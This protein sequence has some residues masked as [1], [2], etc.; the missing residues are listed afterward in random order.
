MTKKKTKDA[1]KLDADFY[2]NEVGVLEWLK[3]DEPQRIRFADRIEYKLN[4]KWH[5]ED[6]PAIEY[7][8][9]I[10]NQFYVFGDKYSDEEH[11]N[12]RRTKLIDQM[13][14]G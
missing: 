13:T 12:Y 3:C 4:N 10:G 7:F 1:P 11:K 8:S 9:G 2:I 6:G 14:N 5:R